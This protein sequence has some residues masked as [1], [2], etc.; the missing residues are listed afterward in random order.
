VQNHPDLGVDV[1]FKDNNILK[2]EWDTIEAGKEE[3]TSDAKSQSSME[4]IYE[5][6]LKEPEVQKR[7]NPD[8]LVVY[9]V[10]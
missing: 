2:S 8:G 4:K 6:L 5:Y 10:Y 3:Q 9:A 1:V 7:L